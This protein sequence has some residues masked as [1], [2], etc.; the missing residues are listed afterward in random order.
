MTIKIPPFKLVPEPLSPEA[1]DLPKFKWAGK[2]PDGREIGTRHKLGGS[3]TSCR[4][5][6]GRRS[7]RT[8]ECP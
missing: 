3:L 5:P 8:V 6:P 4:S 1:A 7:A 2:D